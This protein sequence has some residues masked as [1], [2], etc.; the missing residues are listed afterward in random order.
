MRPSMLLL[1]SSRMAIWTSG[2]LAGRVESFAIAMFVQATNASAVN[3]LMIR[4][5]VFMWLLGVVLVVVNFINRVVE[6]ELDVLA[7]REI[8]Q[9][10]RLLRGEREILGRVE[11][12]AQALRF[13]RL[14]DRGVHPLRGVL[15]KFFPLMN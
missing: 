13:L 4:K 10:T 2:F 7:E 6:N 3:R 15:V 14:L 8:G 5:L 1:V 12:D 9:G 11:L